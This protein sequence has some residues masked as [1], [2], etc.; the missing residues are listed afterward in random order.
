MPRHYRVKDW[1]P[2]DS[3]EVQHGRYLGCR[4]IR[5]HGPASRVSGPRLSTNGT[6]NVALPDRRTR[7]QTAYQG[8]VVQGQRRV[9]AVVMVLRRQAGRKRWRR[10]LGGVVGRADKLILGRPRRELRVGDVVA[11]CALVVGVS[12]SVPLLAAHTAP[13]DAEAAPRTAGPAVTP[14]GRAPR[15]GRVLG[16][17]VSLAPGTGEE[18][19]VSLDRLVR[20]AWSRVGR[21]GEYRCWRRHVCAHHGAAVAVTVSEGPEGMLFARGMSLVDDHTGRFLDR[22]RRGVLVGGKD[23]FLERVR[24][25]FPLPRFDF[26]VVDRRDS[27]FREKTC[28]LLIAPADE[29]APCD[30]YDGQDRQGRTQRNGESLVIVLII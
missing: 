23:G 19:L 28:S 3:E 21:A 11:R 13:A 5:G 14:A 29:D 26:F 20:E 4:F 7:R 6:S 8:L 27:P 22:S 12:V 1:T 30:E 9:D 2:Y 15:A 18:G 16:E 25:V 24:I 10:K 17:A